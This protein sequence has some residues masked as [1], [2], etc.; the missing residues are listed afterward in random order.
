M[1]QMICGMLAD[2]SKRR[3]YTSEQREQWLAKFEQAGTSAVVFCRE[4]QLD[5]SSFQRWRRTSQ[6]T[7]MTKPK[8]DFI[9][10]ELPS[11]SPTSGPG[12]HVELTFP[13]GLTLHI[14]STPSPRS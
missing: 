8:V 14:H 6:S 3:T 11:A 7:E 12:M 1:E 13:G 5:Y 9:E 2:M 4:H 10:V